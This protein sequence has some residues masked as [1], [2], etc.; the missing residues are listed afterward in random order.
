MKTL[1][2][3]LKNNLKDLK[4]TLRDGYSR[5]SYS[6]EGEDLILHR[7]FETV[8]RGFY[9]DVGAHHPKRFSNTFIF[10]QRGW[11][12]INIDAMPGSMEPFKRLRPR[13][14]NVEAAIAS[15]P[16]EMTF[17]VFDDPALNCFG[18]ELAERRWQGAY[19]L[20]QE[21]QI[22]T[23]TL[24]EVLH[25][26]LPTGQKINFLSIDVEGLDLEVLQSNDWSAFRPEYILAECAEMDLEQIQK[27]SV[28]QF[29][30]ER[31]YSLFAKTLSTAVFK[32]NE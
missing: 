8:D 17:F 9:V 2:M 32:A 30:A 18:R 21:I 6:Q 23:Q 10:Y 7:V 12:G 29:L 24:E 4:M 28:Y 31:G 15:S 19:S 1:P 13:D 11:S 5:K 16:R 27:G 3:L 14:I 22:V 26:H 25:S 20:K